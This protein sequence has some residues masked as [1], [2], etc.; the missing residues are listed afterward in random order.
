MCGSGG[1][2]LAGLDASSAKK[3]GIIQIVAG[4]IMFIFA[5]AAVAVNDADFSHGTWGGIVFIFAGVF[6][7]LTG[8]KRDYR[9]TKA[10]LVTAVLSIPF[11]VFF[12]STT[13][14]SIYEIV[15]DSYP[16]GSSIQTVKT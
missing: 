7:L 5:I 16:T 14:I 15:Y 9:R 11:S 4:A 3:S 1:R 2:P 10:A 12:F 8:T 13:V 6:S